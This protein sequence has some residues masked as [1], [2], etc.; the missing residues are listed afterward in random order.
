MYL[1]NWLGEMA[2]ELA[3]AKREAKSAVKSA[4]KVASDS[5]KLAE[6]RLEQLK[7]QGLFRQEKMI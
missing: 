4:K 3:D 5:V 1:N 2:E 7:E 6:R